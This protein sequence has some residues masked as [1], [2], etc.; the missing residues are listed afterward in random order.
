MSKKRHLARGTTIVNRF[1]AT[2]YA[3][4]VQFARHQLHATDSQVGYLYAA[5]GAGVLLLSLLAGPLRR[6]LRFSVVA[7]TA[8]TLDGLVTLGLGLTSSCTVA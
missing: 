1:G 3:Q 4:L 2:T 6:R 8:L 7:L 5:G